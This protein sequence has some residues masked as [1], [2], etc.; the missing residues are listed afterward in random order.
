MYD[1]QRDN[2]P[3]ESVKSEKIHVCWLILWGTGTTWNVMKYKQFR[4]VFL[5]LDKDGVL[6]IINMIRLLSVTPL[7][8]KWGEIQT[9]REREIA[10]SVGLKNRY[11]SALKPD[12]AIK[13]PVCI[14]HDGFIS[15]VSTVWNTLNHTMVVTQVLQCC[16]Y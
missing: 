8:E 2:I 10:D 3:V 13:K 16:L 6:L 11:V 4:F 15:A 5:Y 7:N 12:E 1:Q 14:G 9:E